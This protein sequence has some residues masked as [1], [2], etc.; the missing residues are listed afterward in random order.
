MSTSA[1]APSSSIPLNRNARDGRT[2]KLPGHPRAK[3]QLLAALQRGEGDLVAPGEL[4]NIPPG[5]KLSASVAIR[6]NVPLII[7]AKQG[8]RRYQNLEQL[9]GRSLALPAG[10]VAGEAIRALTSA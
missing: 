7:V 8:N 3:D 6:S 9:S 1:C 4:L 2:L 10:S 5:S